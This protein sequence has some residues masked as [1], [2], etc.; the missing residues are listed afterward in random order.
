[1]DHATGQGVAWLADSTSSRRVW[2]QAS[3]GSG[4]EGFALIELGPA[5]CRDLETGLQRDWLV[6]NGLGEYA[7]GTVAGP[8]TRVS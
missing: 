7:F 3:R 4:S 1:M 2:F 6:T 8:P 5:I